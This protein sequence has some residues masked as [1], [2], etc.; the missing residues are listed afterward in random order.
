[1]IEVPVLTITQKQLIGAFIAV[2]LPALSWTGADYVRTRDTA[3][4]AKQQAEK[5]DVDVREIRQDTL[6]M[7]VLMHTQFTGNA[8]EIARLRAELTRLEKV[9]Q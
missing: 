4:G 8:Q 7:L 1:V 9:S 6:R 3:H 5:L 2:F